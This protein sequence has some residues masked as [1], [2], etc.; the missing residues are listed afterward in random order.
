MLRGN[1]LEMDS[2]SAVDIS[3]NPKIRVHLSNEVQKGQ[4]DYELLQVSKSRIL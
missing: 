4:E 1:G 3:N 2:E